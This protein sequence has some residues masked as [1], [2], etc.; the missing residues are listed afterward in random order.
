[1]RNSA[2][3]GIDFGTSGCRVCAIDKSG[4]ILAQTELTLPASPQPY[5][6]AKQQS[7]FVFATLK[8]LLCQIPDVEVESIVI[9]ATSG[10]VMLCDLQGRPLSEMLMYNDQRAI[11]ASQQIDKTA[12]ADSAAHGPGSG[13]AK[14]LYLQRTLALPEK[15]YLAHQ[16]DWLAIQLGAKPGTTDYNNALKSGFDIV[17]NQWPSWIESLTST[18]VLPNVVTP[19]TVIGKLSESS[20]QKIGLKQSFS[21]ILKAGTTDSLA[22]FIATGAN[23]IG[24]AV[25]SLGSTLV[26]KLICQ[27]P[28]FDAKRGI[29]S[30]KLGKFWLCGGASNSGGAVLRHFFNNE[31]LRTLSQKIDL[32]Q[33]PPDYYP[34]LKSGERFP[35][36]DADY[37]P[38]M[39]PRPAEDHVF[40]YGLLAGIA[41]IEKAGYD[42]LQQLSE[43]KLISIRSVGG[44]SDNSVW[45]RLR[46]SLLRVSFKQTHQTDAAYGSALLARDGLR[47]FE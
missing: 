2:W 11:N 12:P 3:I 15:Y 10:S 26:L 47:L 18:D 37:P 16:A 14:L 29:Y 27:K 40:L 8:N 1:M 44:G 13:L 28:V 43:S 7:H 39:Q 41:S 32:Q 19:G 35:I 23:A 36:A 31:Q 45:T 22:A 33:S 42:C 30:H 9:D 34:L 6:S 4:A 5:P 21:P 24:E 38:R 20:M 25:T 17:N 46:Q